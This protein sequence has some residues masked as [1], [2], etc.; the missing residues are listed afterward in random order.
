MPPA[1]EF[2][3]AYVIS[4]LHLGG[5]DDHQMFASD[6][7]FRAFIAHLVD[8]AQKLRNKVA[9][10]RLLLV[11]NGDFVDFLAEPGS[12]VFNLKRSAEMLH[13]IFGRKRFA[14]V[15]NELQK[16][17]ETPGTH[18]V[19]T[20]GNH[21]VELALPDTRDA[22]LKKLTN[23]NRALQT[24]VE[25]CFDGWGYRFQ[26]AGKHA[27]CLHGNEADINNFTRYD[28]LDRIIH[29]LHLFGKSEFG[30]G[31]PA[32]A[33]S[34]FVINAINPIKQGYPFIDLLKPEPLAAVVLGILDP[35]KA[36]YVVEFTSMANKARDNDRDRPAAQRRMLSV[37]IGGVSLADIA[38]ESSNEQ[39]L[40][41]E[42]IVDYVELALAGGR[43]DELIRLPTQ[44]QF[45]QA[46]DWW[47]PLRFGLNWLKDQG[48]DLTRRVAADFSESA[49]AVHCDALRRAVRG[50][51]TDD[52]YDVGYLAE[53]DVGILAG[54]RAEYDVVFAGHT[55]FR[56]MARRS[57][58]GRC[59]VNTGTWADL[60]GLTRSQVDAPTFRKQ[61]YDKLWSGNRDD[62]KSLI[63]QECTIARMAAGPDGVFVTLG[64]VT[65][66]GVDLLSSK[67]LTEKL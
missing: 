67:A 13:N 58:G 29:D 30:A 12:A 34:W 43:I 52:P 25:F 28:E 1:A 59:Y 49:H 3:L 8:E 50:M 33:G 9:Q 60:I 46:R 66:A 31:W 56:R 35:R 36:P 20:L 6:D 64:G 45:L 53:M 15:L 27:L 62:L 38:P 54:V 11:I 39:A 40:S 21:D 41:K 14:S 37:P 18:L 57:S 61:V 44:G 10:P 42:Q 19:L 63:R 23:G 32:S 26:V 55:H 47:A 48:A 5:D 22:L 24:R 65:A 4:D 7:Q 17:V 2:D 51:V 16:F